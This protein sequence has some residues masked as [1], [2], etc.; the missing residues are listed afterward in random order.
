MLPASNLQLAAPTV[1]IAPKTGLR[2][3]FN[4]MTGNW[5]QEGATPKGTV[6]GMKCGA[7]ATG[8]A[9]AMTAET[10]ASY[11]FAA[12]EVEAGDHIRVT[13]LWHHLPG[14]NGTLDTPFRTQL[15]FGSALLQETVMPAASDAS[16]FSEYWIYLSGSSAQTVIQRHFRTADNSFLATQAVAALAAGLDEASIYFHA[17]SSNGSGSDD[18]V[19][20]TAYCVELVKGNGNGF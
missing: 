10:L 7:G 2:L 16:L 11:V 15:K 18:S 3:M 17:R 19:A 12:D 8:S 9:G 6:R 4:A 5:I 13:A 14:A 20:L 1:A